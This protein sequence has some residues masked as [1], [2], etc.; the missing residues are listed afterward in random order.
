MASHRSPHGGQTD[1]EILCRARALHDDGY[2]RRLRTATGASTN[3]AHRGGGHDSLHEQPA[4]GGECLRRSIGHGD[5]HQTGGREYDGEPP[6]A[7]DRA[8]FAGCPARGHRRREEP[9]RHPEPRVTH[10]D[11]HLESSVIAIVG[12]STAVATT[13]WKGYLYEPRREARF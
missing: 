11:L 12:R 1:E 10:V 3:R 5:I 7:W 6:C 8:R 4:A 13:L 2:V 9:V